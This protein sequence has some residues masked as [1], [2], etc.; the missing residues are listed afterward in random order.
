VRQSRE[1]AATEVNIEKSVA[2]NRP[3]DECYRFWRNFENFP[4]FMQHVQ[5]VRVLSDTRSHWIVK[6]PAG[7]TVEWD[8]EITY[9]QPN[10]LLVWHSVEGADVDHAG[11]IRFEPSVDGSSTVLHVEMQYR[12][13]GGKAGALIAKLFG[14]EPEQQIEEDI[15]RFRQLIETGEIATTLGQSSGRRSIVGRL[16]RKGEP[17]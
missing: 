11:Q 7:I 5:D 4:R 1:L 9:D 10:Q 12:P 14:E 3:V 15:R 13:P 17:G 6:A 8:A 16:L 2:I